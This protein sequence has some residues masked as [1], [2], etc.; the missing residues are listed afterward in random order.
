MLM[1]HNKVQ[2]GVKF[3]INLI[4]LMVILKT[5]IQKSRWILKR[6]SNSRHFSSAPNEKK[7]MNYFTAI[8]DAMRIAMMTDST[9]IIFGED[10]GFGGVF[11]CSIGLQEEF[12][13]HRV[14]NTP[15]CEQGIVGFGIG[16]ASV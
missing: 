2:L 8:N 15:L 14:F 5:A 11:R 3:Y 6:L 13:S 10:V 9:A 7:R 4:E 12:G 16:Y 1:R